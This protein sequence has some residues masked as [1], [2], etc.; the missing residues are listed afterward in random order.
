MPLDKVQ[1]ES[2]I[3]IFKKTRKTNLSILQDVSEAQAKWLPEG[4][5]NHILWHAGHIFVLVERCIFA[6]MVGSDDLPSSIPDGWWPMFGWNSKPWEIEL[7]AWP[8]IAC[9]RRYLAQQRD[10]LQDHP[11]IFDDGFLSSPITWSDPRWYGHPR[12][13]V[14]THGFFDELL[15]LGQVMQL[16]RLYEVIRSDQDS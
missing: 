12:R 7:E 5:V 2:L 13:N 10:Q 6:A 1:D 14:I 9:V 15:H 11:F 4:E 3:I 8:S 16:K